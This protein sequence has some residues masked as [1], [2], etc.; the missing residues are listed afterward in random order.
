MSSLIMVS[1]RKTGKAL[2][3]AFDSTKWVERRT[4][5]AVNPQWLQWVGDRF[6]MITSTGTGYKKTWWSFDPTVDLCINGSGGGNVIGVNLN[7]S[8]IQDGNDQTTMICNAALTGNNSST[9]ISYDLGMSWTSK[10]TGASGAIHNPTR[11]SVPDGTPVWLI[12]IA[13]ATTTRR[14]NDNGATW[15]AGPVVPGGGRIAYSPTLGIWINVSNSSGK[16]MGAWW[17][18]DLVT[19]TAGTGT[20][21]A[22]IATSTIPAGNETLRW[23]NDRFIGIEINTNVLFYS[24]DGKNWNEAAFPDIRISNTAVSKVIYGSGVWIIISQNSNAY[25]YSIDGVNWSLGAF[26]SGFLCYCGEYGNGQFVFTRPS[27]GTG[28]STLTLLTNSAEAHNEFFNFS[29]SA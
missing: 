23:I 9:Y 11:G 22:L 8:A 7:F 15:I 19:W 20:A 12:K 25:A 3:G 14:S 28:T 13:G 29:I 5:V 2:T 18:T 1:P 16:G 24:L 6:V 10:A 21:G 4:S 26:P 27:L 17:S